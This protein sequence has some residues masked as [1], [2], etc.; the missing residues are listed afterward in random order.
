MMTCCLAFNTGTISLLVEEKQASDA[1]ITTAFLS[2][3]ALATFLP[4]SLRTQSVT[5]YISS[6]HCTA[7]NPGN[8][9]VM[10]KFLLAG[11]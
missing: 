1:V 4:S 11:Q 5:E 8:L 9:I 10:Y 2:G 3:L 7:A 6:T